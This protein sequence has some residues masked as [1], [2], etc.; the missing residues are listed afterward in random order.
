MHPD[1]SV[2]VKDTQLLKEIWEIICCQFPRQ[3]EKSV[4]RNGR[5]VA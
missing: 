4:I 2:I 3:N 1:Q 5:V